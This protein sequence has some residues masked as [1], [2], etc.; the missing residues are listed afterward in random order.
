LI[1][2][3]GKSQSLA[4]AV[5]ALDLLDRAIEET[6]ESAAS[7]VLRQEWSAAMTAARVLPKE[8]GNFFGPV[9]AEVAELV[10]EAAADTQ[11]SGGEGTARG[12]LRLA[13]LLLEFLTSEGDDSGLDGWEVDRSLLVEYGTKVKECMQEFT[14]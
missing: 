12:R 1:R 2:V 11:L 3:S 6:P 5:K 13:S 8:P 14:S 9:F 4:T 10:K 7:E